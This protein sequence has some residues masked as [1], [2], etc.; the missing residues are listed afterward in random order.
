MYSVQWIPHPAA[1]S[2]QPVMRQIMDM[3]H[4]TAKSTKNAVDRELQK[5]VEGNMNRKCYKRVAQ[6]FYPSR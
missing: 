3:I 2:H 5:L 4:D 6:T 1:P